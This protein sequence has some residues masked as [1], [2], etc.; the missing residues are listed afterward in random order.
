MAAKRNQRLLVP[1]IY[2]ALPE[3]EKVIRS[4]HQLI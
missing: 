2:F 3:I 4:C 1:E